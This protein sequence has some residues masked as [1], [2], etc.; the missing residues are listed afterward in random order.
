[1]Q[2][3]HVP[4]TLAI[5]AVAIVIA[6]GGALG[7][8]VL[9][10]GRN[11]A[12][13]QETPIAAPIRTRQAE[14]ELRL[15]VPANAMAAA[16]IAVE[17]VRSTSF[18]D[19]ASGLATVLSPQTL[20]DQRRTYQTAAAEAVR[21]GLS[22]SAARR[23]VD[24]LTTLY[25]DDRLVS[26]KALEA[27]RVIAGTEDAN[28][29]NARGQIAL[30]TATLAR[31]WGPVIAAGVVRGSSSMERV[32]AGQ[33]VLL[34]VA[35]TA[36]QPVSPPTQVRLEPTS[37]SPLDVA[38]VSR[39]PIADPRFQ[40]QSFYAI[41]P[42]DD[43]LLPGMSVE[44]TVPTA[45]PTTGVSIPDAAVV[46]WQGQPF[47]YVAMGNDEFVRR[48]IATDIATASG[49]LVKTG[50]ADGARVVVHGAQLLLSEELKTKSP[51]NPG[52]QSDVR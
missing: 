24:R 37:G 5:A 25:A 17:P 47:V 8:R 43:R 19:H 31:Q 22:V 13:K 11:A 39:S 12:S 4:R 40:A 3:R 29:K 15:V 49:W 36:R 26:A 52:G 42:A 6:V 46:R 20:L 27:A 33:S 44:A 50:V 1:M 21:A 7:L 28:L 34:Q 48:P 23:E 16:G 41:A 10:A 38:I 9:G 2:R 18:Q 32:F 51:S 35:L 14:G 45:A 30:L